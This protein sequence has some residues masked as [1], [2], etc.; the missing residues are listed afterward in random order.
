ME[1]KQNLKKFYIMISICIFL[2][3]CVV[4]FAIFGFA[5]Y[6]YV[7]DRDGQF[8]NQ[9]GLTFIDPT[10]GEQ[11]MDGGKTSQELNIYVSPF[12]KNGN[13]R[14]ML[15]FFSIISLISFIVLGF[16]ALFYF[17][18]SKDIPPKVKEKY[19]DSIDLKHENN[20]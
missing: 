11:I 9:P 17:L 10:N 4:I 6:S 20:F 3:I 14:L 1:K 15:A 8:L 12:I 18:N 7:V 16:S 19:K 13:I 2:F 5:G